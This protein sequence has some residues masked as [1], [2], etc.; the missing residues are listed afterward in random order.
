MPV[1]PLLGSEVL[2][3][4]LETTEG[5]RLLPHVPPSWAGLHRA[6]AAEAAAVE[7]EAPLTPA[8]PARRRLADFDDPAW[9]E[10]EQQRRLGALAAH[11]TATGGG[12]ELLSGWGVE[13]HARHDARG[14]AGSYSVFV[15]ASGRK[16]RTRAEVSRFF[17]LGEGGEAG[18]GGE[19]GEDCEEDGDGG[20]GG[21]QSSEER[22]GEAPERNET[23]AGAPVGP[24]S[25]RRPSV[26]LVPVAVRGR[27]LGGQAVDY[28]AD[29][30]GQEG[31]EVCGVFGCTLPLHHEHWGG[32][33]D[34]KVPCVSG[35]RHRS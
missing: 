23:S 5:A 14:R 27:L 21:G 20:D 9:V 34:H 26:T 10:H 24:A 13:I 6:K 32:P 35:K 16:F 2:L 12:R 4:Y 30:A 19:D 18:D 11:L 29:A 17:G 33:K 15:D 3:A 31:A 28:F 7:A 8:P 22:H 25:P 1:Q